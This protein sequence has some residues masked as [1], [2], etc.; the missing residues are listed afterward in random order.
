MRAR[1]DGPRGT[2]SVAALCTAG[3]AGSG[4][5]SRKR[6]KRQ[7]SV[8][9]PIPSGPPIIQACARRL[10]AIGVEQF[11]LRRRM[12][13]QREGL[14]RMRRVVETV[15]LR[16]ARRRLPLLIG[17]AAALRG[18]E[19]A[20]RRAARWPRATS[21][22]GWQRVDDAAALRARCA[23]MSRK[24]R[25]SPRG[26]QPSSRLETIGASAPPR[27]A[28]GARAGPTSR[29]QVEN[30]RQVRPDR[31]DSATCS[32]SAI[33][34]AARR[35][36]ARPD[37][38]ASNRRNGRRAP[39]RR[40]PAPARSARSTW[41]MRAAAKSDRPPPSGPSGASRPESSTSRSASACGEP[42]GSR[43]V[44]A[45]SPARAAAPRGGAS[46]SICRRPRRPR[47]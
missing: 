43:V 8:A 27:R 35:R 10:R 28:R 4:C 25:R 14:A 6:A 19:T 34:V 31:A 30:D 2:A 32:S 39:R 38:R 13:E 47:T 3:A 33:S 44:T 12:A 42:P 26:S 17:A 15:A 20:P 29:R 37:R 7:A 11:A 22:S 21:S 18:R 23:A 1:R 16:R 5:A 46:A 41:S 24:A 9:L 45:S 36:R 40:A